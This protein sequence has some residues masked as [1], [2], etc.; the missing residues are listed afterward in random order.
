MVAIP[1]PTPADGTIL[2]WRIYPPGYVRLLHTPSPTPTPTPGPVVL[3]VHGGSWD[4][5]SP[6]QSDVEKACEALAQSGFWVFSCSYRLSAC[7]RIPGQPPHDGTTT[8]EKAGHPPKLTDDVMALM[9]AARHNSNCNGKVGILGVSVGGFLASYVALD[10]HVI[11]ESGRPPWNVD[12]PDNRPECLVTFSSPFDL[13]D[14]DAAHDPDDDPIYIPSVQNYI[15]NCDRGIARDDSPISLIDSGTAA[16]FKP[17]LM[18]Q[19][20][21]D[22]TNPHRQIDDMAIA[23][24]TAGVNPCDYVVTFLPS[25]AEGGHALILWHQEDPN[26][27]DHRTVGDS[28][29]NF[30]HAH[31]DP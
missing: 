7:G 30:F 4:G 28:T 16:N 13:A 21:H 19:A 3:V 17:M 11:N 31:L 9:I 2:Q 27:T 29:L 18:V 15:G 1:S 20:F 8:N 6:F 12:R 14:Q 23:L 5:G 10:R 26:Y 25:T 22:M 24:N